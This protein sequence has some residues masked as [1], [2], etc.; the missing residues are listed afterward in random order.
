MLVCARSR[1]GSSSS[2]CAMWAW[3]HRGCRQTLAQWPTMPQLGQASSHA[4]LCAPVVPPW[5]RPR[6]PAWAPPR[7]LRGLP[8]LR[9]PVENPPPVTLAGLPLSLSE[10]ELLANGDRPRERLRLIAVDDLEATYCLLD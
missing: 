5:A 7:A 1:A 4:G 8:R 9:P 10:M 6:T 3:P 2:T